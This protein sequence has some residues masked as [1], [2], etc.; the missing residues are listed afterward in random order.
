M[1]LFRNNYNHIPE[2][3]LS[4]EV[5]LVKADNKAC[6]TA[7]PLIYY[8]GKTVTQE[9]FEGLCEG[10]MDFKHRCNK[11]FQAVKKEYELLIGQPVNYYKYVVEEP[12]GI[13]RAE[14]QMRSMMI[15]GMLSE[16]EYLKEFEHPET[17]GELILDYRKDLTPIRITKG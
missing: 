7:N 12:Q 3:I 8:I 5:D 9:V 13:E 15:Q 4:S 17:K 10:Y 6:I 2:S 14:A 16:E 11:L 1:N